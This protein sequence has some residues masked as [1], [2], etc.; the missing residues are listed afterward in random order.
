MSDLFFAKFTARTD[1]GPSGIT[2]NVGR[3]CSLSIHSRSK[4]ELT[5]LGAEN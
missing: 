4:N 1:L 5:N 2:I 3:T